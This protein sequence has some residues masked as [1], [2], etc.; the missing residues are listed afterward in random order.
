MGS[1]CLTLRLF[2]NESG[3]DEWAMKGGIYEH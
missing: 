1:R 3:V 2:V